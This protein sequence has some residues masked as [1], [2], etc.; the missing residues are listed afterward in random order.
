M[1]VQLC[2]SQTPPQCVWLHVCPMQRPNR[3]DAVA[4]PAQSLRACHPLCLRT[5]ARQVTVHHHWW[6]TSC[7]RQHALVQHHQPTATAAAAAAAA[8]CAVS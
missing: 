8:A 4:A 1:C 7:H 3:A 6:S 2:V 5:P